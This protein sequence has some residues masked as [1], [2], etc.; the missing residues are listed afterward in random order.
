[1]II[2]Y[3]YLSRGLWGTW[4]RETSKSTQITFGVSP[5]PVSSPFNNS[6]KDFPLTFLH[7]QAKNAK[8]NNHINFTGFKNQFFLFQTLTFSSWL[9]RASTVPTYLPDHLLSSFRGVIET[10]E[11]FIWVCKTIYFGIKSGSAY[12]YWKWKWSNYNLLGED[13]GETFGEEE[14]S[15]SKKQKQ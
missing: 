9:P 10:D 4:E 3:L 13:V 8:A 7:L 6:F 15:E 2:W 12:A 5:F 14:A 11:L 1:M